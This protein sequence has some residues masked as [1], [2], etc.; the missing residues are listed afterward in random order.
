MTVQAER[1]NLVPCPD[2]GRNCSKAAPACPD[3]GRPLIAAVTST[4]PEKI[5]DYVLNYSFM[6]VGL[7]LT[8]LGLV[9]LV[10]GLKHLSTLADELLAAN[11]VIFLVSGLLTYLAIKHPVHKR[12][13]G[14]GRTADLIFSMG[15][16]FLAGICC[17][18]AVSLI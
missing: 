7:C 13:V 9:R 8:L 14:M 11:A 3:C 1:P 17:V 12:K 5:Y 6:M 16:I 18:I 15:I 2:C 10:E 4:P